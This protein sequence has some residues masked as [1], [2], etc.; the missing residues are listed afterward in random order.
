MLSRV[1]TS[2]AFSVE[3]RTSTRLTVITHRPYPAPRRAVKTKTVYC[4]RSE[5]EGLMADVTVFVKPT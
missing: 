2:V 4:R 1:P 5:T 3:R